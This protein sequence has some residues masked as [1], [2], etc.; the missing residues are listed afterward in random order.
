MTEMTIEEKA[1]R[2]AALH[3]GPDILILPN[4]WDRGSARILAESGFPAIATTSA[5][6]AFAAG[7]P[8]GHKLN[9]DEMCAAVKQCADIISVPLTADMEAGYGVTPEDV[10]QSVRQAIAGG[11]VGANIEDAIEGDDQGDNGPMIDIA[12]ATDR[13]R[14]GRAASDALGIDFVLNARTDVYLYNKGATDAMF[15]EAV[16]RANA[17]YAAGARCVYVP[18]VADPDL[19]A[20]LA[21]AIEGPLNILAGPTSP[22]TAEL[23]NLGVA[24]VSI[25]GSLARASLSL[26][27]AAAAELRGPGTYSYAAGAFSNTELNRRFS[28]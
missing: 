22:T 2:F 18:G 24:R 3:E 20:R 16:A 12:L 11:A 10:A 19:I 5:G 9:R 7:L 17:Y 27:A 13:I 4:C 1:T 26:V 14:A 21:R 25:G 6:V 15:D 23:Q 8:D 28:S